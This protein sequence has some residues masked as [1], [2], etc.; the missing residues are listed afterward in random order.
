M[1]HFFSPTKQTRK[2]D[3]H[4]R[5]AVVSPRTVLPTFLDNS[6]ASS[7][8]RA[9]DLDVFLPT[10]FLTPVGKK[11]TKNGWT[12]PIRSNKGRSLP[13]SHIGHLLG[14]FANL[15]LPISW[16]KTKPSWQKSFLV[17]F[18]RIRFKNGLNQLAKIVS[19]ALLAR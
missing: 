10:W 17:P 18:S 11:C 2:N 4:V 6:I 1:S 15:V 19:C 3:T 9:I 5:D 8:P 14:V 7:R 16:S 13:I 12:L